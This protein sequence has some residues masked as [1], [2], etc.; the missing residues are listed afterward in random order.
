LELAFQ[1]EETRGKIEAPALLPLVV[2]DSTQIHQLLHN[3][4][5]NSL[6]YHKSGETPR[7][8]IQANTFHNNMIR[9]EVAD[10]GIGID[11]GYQ[12]DV[13]TMFRRLH[14]QSEYEGTGIGLAVCKKIV[15]RHGGEIGVESTLGQ[16]STFWFTIPSFDYHTY[17]NETENLLVGNDLS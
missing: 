17:A 10:N 6:K 4:I 11:H 14:S 2:A 16:G 15:Q 5:S 12:D 8:T 13:F 1:L 7:I 3:L 9:V